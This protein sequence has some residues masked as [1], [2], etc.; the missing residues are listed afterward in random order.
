MFFYFNLRF[1]Q[2]RICGACEW[3]AVSAWAA[4]KPAAFFFWRKA[5][6]F[7]KSSRWSRPTWPES[8]K[9]R[10]NHWRPHRQ[11]GKDKSRTI[12]EEGT[13]RF[14]KVRALSAKIGPCQNGQRALLPEIPSS[15]NNRWNHG[16]P[17]SARRKV[18]RKRALISRT[19]TRQGEVYD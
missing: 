10:R 14:L 5:L 8:W 16:T 4:A 6:R 3:A 18:V 9:A 11:I 2:A 17:Q 13:Q 1:C 7:R 12:R 19:A 15:N